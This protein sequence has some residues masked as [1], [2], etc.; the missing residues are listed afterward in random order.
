MRMPPEQVLDLIFAYSIF[1]GGYALVL[2]P[3]LVASFGS[4]RVS[5]NQCFVIY[6]ILAVQA[7][8]WILAANSFSTGHASSSEQDKSVVPI[9]AGAAIPFPI[10]CLWIYFLSRRRA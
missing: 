4:R 6:G 5:R 1:Y 9:V 8:I 10:A 3:L 7:A 2:V